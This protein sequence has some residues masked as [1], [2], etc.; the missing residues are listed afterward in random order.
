MLPEVRIAHVLDAIRSHH[1]GRLSCVEAGELLGLRERHFRRLRDAHEDRGEE[2]L[3]DRRRGRV[4][5]AR[6][7][8]E[9]AAWL[10]QMF[11]T[12]YFDFTVKH[13]HEQ[14]VGQAMANGKTFH[15]SRSCVKSVLQPRGLTTKAR[16]GAGSIAASAS[17][18]RCRA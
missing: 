1:A 8:D 10:A 3:V 13:F 6:V 9:E 12:R 18:V 17:G 15:R 14:I 4:S 2:G 16:P 5:S 7:P 11:R